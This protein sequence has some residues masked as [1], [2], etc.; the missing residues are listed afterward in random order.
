M[1]RDFIKSSLVAKRL[2]CHWSVALFLFISLSFYLNF[3]GAK[4]FGKQIQD[5]GKAQ[6]EGSLSECY[7]KFA[8]YNG[9]SVKGV[10]AK[11]LYGKVMCGY[12]GWFGAPG[13]G[14]SNNG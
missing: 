5:V 8:G 2:A 14:G 9:Q 10:D 4:L 7:A 1:Q 3:I 11:T 12:Q 6:D 13:D